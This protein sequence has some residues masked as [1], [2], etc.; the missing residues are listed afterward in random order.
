LIALYEVTFDEKWLGQ[1]IEL[2]DYAI[3]HYY[4]RAAGV[5]Y[6]TADDV[7]E[8]IARKSEIMDG[9]IS[10]S[11]SVMAR[12]LKKLGLLFDDA[13]YLEISTQ[14]LRNMMPHMAKY[15]SAYSNWATLLLD[16]VFGVYE[17]AITGPGYE[18]GR[19]EIENN[20]IPNKIILGGTKGSL[21]LLTDKFGDI[22]QVFICKDK[23]CSLPVYNTTDALKQINARILL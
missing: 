1:A 6:F 3:A 15:G 5:F 2:A 13:E 23:T 17:V 21:P 4:D 11:N 22:T 12:N 18:T 14:Q 19:I 9:V 10:S 20:Y 7:E 16:E 8:L